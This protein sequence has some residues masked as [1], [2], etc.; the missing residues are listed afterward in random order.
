MAGP[1]GQRGCDGAHREG[2]PAAGGGGG[3]GTPL[4]PSCSGVLSPL[5]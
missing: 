5:C 4:L 2:L 1:G 3:T